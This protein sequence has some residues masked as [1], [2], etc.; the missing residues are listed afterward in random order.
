MKMEPRLV[1]YR[2]S[3][4]AR[5]QRPIT[6]RTKWTN[7]C[8]RRT[9]TSRRHRPPCPRM[10]REGQQLDLVRMVAA[11]EHTIEVKAA[12]M[13]LH[14]DLRARS[15]QL[16]R[17]HAGALLASNLRRQT[18][19]QRAHGTIR[20]P[21]T[22]AIEHTVG[23]VRIVLNGR[24]ILGEECR[25][26][27]RRVVRT[28][29]MRRVQRHFVPGRTSGE[30]PQWTRIKIHRRQTPLTKLSPV[31]AATPRRVEEVGPQLAEANIIQVLSPALEVHRARHR[32]D[33]QVRAVVAIVR[34][35][36]RRSH[37]HQRK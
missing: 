21:M 1:Q 37:N 35:H 13:H 8:S 29:K 30:A 2:L 28:M 22:P 20:Q 19:E 32:R 3:T 34:Y 11:G 18:F 14:V 7:G 9:T 23:M 17:R 27:R 24:P 25:R 16:V 5:R 4:S 26:V 15:R 33:G 12:R 6:R 36:R 31:Q 10:V